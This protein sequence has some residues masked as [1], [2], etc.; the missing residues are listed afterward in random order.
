[1][2]C[3]MT[4]FQWSE[5]RRQDLIAYV[6]S[7]PWGDLGPSIMDIEV[8]LLRAVE[9][10]AEAMPLWDEMEDHLGDEF[11][12]SDVRVQCMTLEQR[13]AYVARL[14]LTVALLYGV[15]LRATAAHR[16]R[17]IHGKRK[18]QWARN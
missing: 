2:T 12:I 16:L 14:V 9:A 15:S 6:E 3:L 18:R 4:G 8:G 10:T 13:L 5:A 11:H 7:L 17:R 1:M